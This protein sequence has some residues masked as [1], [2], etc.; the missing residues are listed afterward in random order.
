MIGLKQGFIYSTLY[1]NLKGRSRL[2]S[3]GLG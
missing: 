1:S 3:L 2:G